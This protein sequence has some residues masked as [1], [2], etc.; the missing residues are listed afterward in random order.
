MTGP[1]VAPEDEAGEDGAPKL[2]T[3]RRS[4]L[5]LATQ[6]LVARYWGAFLAALPVAG[7]IGGMLTKAFDRGVAEGATATTI[8]RHTEQLTTLDRGL[9]AEAAV[10]AEAD[11]H[12]QDD[13]AGLKV[14]ASQIQTEL[15]YI[16][17]DVRDIKK[18][19]GQSKAGAPH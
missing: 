18:A 10:R 9:A 8:Q 4:R 17:D 5:G 13:V 16:G 14:S 1:K 7:F 15:K 19:V 3:R 6:D 2:P 12:I 11:K